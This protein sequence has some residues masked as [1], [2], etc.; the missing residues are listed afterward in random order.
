MGPNHPINGTR[1]W[2]FGPAGCVPAS[3]TLRSEG[4]RPT[5]YTEAMAFAD[6]R[7]APPTG[8]QRD[9]SVADLDRNATHFYRDPSG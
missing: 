6:V 2:T 5:G 9:I 1:L 4:E 8:L 7:R 3:Q